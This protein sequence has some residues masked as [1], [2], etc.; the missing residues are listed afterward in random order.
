MPSGKAEHHPVEPSSQGSATTM[1]QARLKPVPAPRTRH[2][3]RASH[4]VGLS[5]TPDCSEHPP[6]GAKGVCAGATCA[7]E[8]GHEGV[9]GF[10]T[11]LSGTCELG[12]PFNHSPVR[13]AKNRHECSGRGWGGRGGAVSLHSCSRTSSSPRPW[14]VLP[15]IKVMAKG[16]GCASEP[17]GVASALTR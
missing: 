17:S 11:I 4:S 9:P 1:S 5:P 13:S 14:Q 6:P 16:P 7:G 12:S 10:D 8:T 3:V 15:E 2:E